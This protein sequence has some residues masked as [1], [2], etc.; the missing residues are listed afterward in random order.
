[1][2]GE[3]YLPDGR[4]FYSWAE[5]EEMPDRNLP[6][7]VRGKRWSDHAGEM[8]FAALDGHAGYALPLCPD[9]AR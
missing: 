3:K 7:P 6:C 4:R 2:S 8:E 5:V 9:T 1:V